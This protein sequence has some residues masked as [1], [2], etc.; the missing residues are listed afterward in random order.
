MIERLDQTLDRIEEQHNPLV[1]N[2][3][4][5]DAAGIWNYLMPEVP[6]NQ[7]RLKQ[8]ENFNIIVPKSINIR[9][10]NEFLKKYYGIIVN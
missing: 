4:D 10:G 1:V 8:L 3:H 9:K 7:E 6:L 2:Y 5:F